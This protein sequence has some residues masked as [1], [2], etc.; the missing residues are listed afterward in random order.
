V[1]LTYANQL[2][3]LRMIFIPCFVLLLIYGY[4]KSATAVFIFA[5]ITDGLDGLLARKLQQKTALGSF[6]DPMADKLL[7]TAAFVTLTIPSVPVAFH[8]PIWLTIT[9]ISRDLLIALAVLIIHLHTR[10]TQFPPSL[11]GKCTTTAQLVTVGAALVGHFYP[12][13]GMEIFPPV[14]YSTLA[15]TVVSGLHYFY[16]SVH[17]I[18]RYQRPD[19]ANGGARHQDQ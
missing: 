15:L 17:I 14:V 19:T 16:R 2:T 4:L 11:L 1:I 8:I 3:I 6:L 12:G 18:E 7:I 10:H 9:S 5:G 13:F